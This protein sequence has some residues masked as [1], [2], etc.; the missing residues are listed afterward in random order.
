MCCSTHCVSSR[1][2]AGRRG[3]GG[4]A[5]L[6]ASKGSPSVPLV[7]GFRFFNGF[8]ISPADRTLLARLESA[9][10][11]ANGEDALPIT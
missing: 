5:E 6:H 1:R 7:V 3:G 8:R 11:E 4:G 9:G 10:D 2:R